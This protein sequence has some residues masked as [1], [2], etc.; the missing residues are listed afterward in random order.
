MLALVRQDP[1]KQWRVPI[2]DVDG[3]VVLSAE[4]VFQLVHV[5]MEGVRAAGI[6]PPVAFRTGS[7]NHS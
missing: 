7:S 5:S 1:L 2:V 6:M 3:L 4:L